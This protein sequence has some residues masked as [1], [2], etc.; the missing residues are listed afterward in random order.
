MNAYW[1]VLVF[2]LL[3]HI[4]AAVARRGEN[5][6]R[7][8]AF[9]WSLGFLP[10]LVLGLV[11]T[12]G[13][14]FE[15][16]TP[17]EASEAIILGGVIGLGA[18][19]VAT[20]I[21]LMHWKSG[22][23]LVLVTAAFSYALIGLFLPFPSFLSLAPWLAG[24]LILLG[25][26]L[27]PHGIIRL[28]HANLRGKAGGLTVT[29]ILLGPAVILAP[30]GAAFALGARATDPYAE[31]FLLEIT[32]DNDTV[33]YSL[34]VPIAPI[35]DT[36][37]GRRLQEVL[38]QNA[39][40]TDGDGS[41]EAAPDGRLR[42]IATGPITVTSSIEFYGHAPGER[43]HGT[44]WGDNDVDVGSLQ[45]V[46]LGVHWLL[47]NDGGRSAGCY[48]DRAEFRFILSQ[49]GELTTPGTPVSFVCAD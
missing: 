40:I 41:I 32:P 49:D 29:A 36:A 19:G 2:L 21:L 31:A 22:R 25:A 6:H 47:R 10:A 33:G 42:V 48:L 46:Q 45:P 3:F 37:A 13:I 4:A 14:A 24:F 43:V 34:L 9:L 27:I 28:W 11:I 8:K 35:S 7:L 17:V 23:P 16:N 15:Q 39:R 38:L 1:A 20:L 5:A 12:L 44:A 18:L 30:L 26:L